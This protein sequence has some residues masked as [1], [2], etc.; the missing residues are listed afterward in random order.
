MSK[1]T[2]TICLS[3]LN[4]TQ[5]IK[6]IKSTIKG[7]E[8]RKKRKEKKTTFRIHL[9]QWSKLIAIKWLGLT[10]IKVILYVFLALNNRKGYR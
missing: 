4:M 8:Q 1:N 9:G 7:K 2:G 10:V 6:K 3:S 5:S